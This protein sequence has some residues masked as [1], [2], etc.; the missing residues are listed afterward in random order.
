MFTWCES[1]QAIIVHATGQDREYRVNK[2]VRQAARHKAV[3]KLAEHSNA[4]WRAKLKLSEHHVTSN[5]PRIKAGDVMFAE[6]LGTG[7]LWDVGV[8]CHRHD[9]NMCDRK[10]LQEQGLDATSTLKNVVRKRFL[11]T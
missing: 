2:A 4:G 5:N 6:R 10:W 7:R 8:R 9:I 3:Q 11:F 1:P